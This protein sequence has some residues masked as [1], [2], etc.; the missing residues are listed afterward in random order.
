MSG[1][2]I[3]PY[4]HPTNGTLQNQNPLIGE[5][6]FEGDP[7]SL[8]N[9]TKSDPDPWGYVGFCNVS[10]LNKGLELDVESPAF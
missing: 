7:V 6:S 2:I 10:I 8:Y 1:I 4:F 9:L 5:H 3:E